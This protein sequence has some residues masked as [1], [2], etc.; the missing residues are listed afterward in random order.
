MANDEDEE[1]EYGASLDQRIK[2]EITKKQNKK[3]MCRIMTNLNAEWLYH[4]V[5]LIY[6][7][8]NYNLIFDFQFFRLQTEQPPT[9]NGQLALRAVTRHP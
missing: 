9:L 1:G 7:N 5:N 8:I 3:R 2:T 6:Y 4:E